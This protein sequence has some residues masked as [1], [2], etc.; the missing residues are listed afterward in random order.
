[1]PTLFTILLMLAVAYAYFRQGL[2]HSCAMCA[3][4]FLAGLIAFGFWEPIADGIE[5]VF[6]GT[7]LLGYEDAL[8]LMA[9]FCFSLLL[10]RLATSSLCPSALGY[11]PAVNLGGAVLFGLGTGYLFSGFFL[12]VLQTLPW[13]ENFMGYDPASR[14]GK[15]V[16]SRIM[17]PDR[18]W[19]AAMRTAGNRPFAFRTDPAVKGDAPYEQRS[20][21]FDKYATF[22]PRYARYRRYNDY[23]NPYP[24]QGELDREIHRAPAGK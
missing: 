1:M 21:T 24:Y 14:A 19:L 15:G 18:A 16:F 7:F 6:D 13:H 11:P 20:I 2:L 4:V 22:A 23:R 17:P 12:C 5:E 3:N 10:L 9:L 8:S